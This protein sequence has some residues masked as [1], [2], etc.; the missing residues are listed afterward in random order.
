MCLFYAQ[1]GRYVRYVLEPQY[2]DYAGSQAPA[3][4]PSEQSSSFA[5]REAG[6]SYSEFPSWSLGTSANATIAGV[7]HTRGDEPLVFLIKTKT[8]YDKEMEVCLEF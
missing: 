3:W 5:R 6:A 4:E 1:A 7:P 8:L 2:W